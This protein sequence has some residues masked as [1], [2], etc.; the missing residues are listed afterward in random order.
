MTHGTVRTI[1]LS[2][3][4]LERQTLVRLKFTPLLDCQTHNAELTRF[5]DAGRLE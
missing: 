4:A 1:F 3:P 2:F 5:Y